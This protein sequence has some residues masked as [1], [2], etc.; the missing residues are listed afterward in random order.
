MA[1]LQK[2]KEALEYYADG[3]DFD[4]DSSPIIAKEALAELKE[5]MEGG[6]VY[7]YYEDPPRKVW[8]VAPKNSI[9][10]SEVVAECKTEEQAKFVTE[11]CNKA[12]AAINVIKEKN[13]V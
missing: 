4:G 9:A 13:N 8:A 1:D 5:F 3:G 6:K 2:V 12:Q 7:I 10:Q 11:M